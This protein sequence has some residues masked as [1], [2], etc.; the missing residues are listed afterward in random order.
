MFVQTMNDLQSPFGKE[1]LSQELVTFEHI[2][3]NVKQSLVITTDDK[4]N[5]WLTQISKKLER[6]N[7]WIAPFGLV[8][9]ITLAVITSTFKDWVFKP[10]TWKAV[11][12]LIDIASCAWLISTLR[13]CSKKFDQ[14]K[15][16]DE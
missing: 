15:A 7:S 1:M 12:I 16:I 6:R 5:L 3:V 4:L 14:I 11:F 10:D 8:I 2:H 9:S 13:Y